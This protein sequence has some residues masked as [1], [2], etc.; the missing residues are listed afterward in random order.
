[1]TQFLTV[2][3]E[4]F[5]EAV[6]KIR[7]DNLSAFNRERAQRPE[8]Q[9]FNVVLRDA[10]NA[11]HGGISAALHYDVLYIDDLWIEKA[12]R[13]ADYGTKLMRLA[14]EEGRRRG[15]ALWWLDTY[16]WQARPFYK[17][18]GYELFGELPYWGTKPARHFM[19]KTL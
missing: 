19:R 14:E 9:R 15:A 5:S 8:P 6:T 18:L 2:A 10:G 12:C 11:V 17:K 4:P 16:T 7:T 3:V 1:V 13:G